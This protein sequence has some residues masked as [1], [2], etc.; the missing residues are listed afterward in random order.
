VIGRRFFSTR[1]ALARRSPALTEFRVS[2]KGGR[3]CRAGQ[4][5]VLL[6]R[7]GVHTIERDRRAIVDSAN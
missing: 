3:F 5:S 7:T 4:Q 2:L 6:F 1:G